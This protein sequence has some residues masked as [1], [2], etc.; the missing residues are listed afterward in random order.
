MVAC[1]GQVRAGFVRGGKGRGRH[2]PPRRAAA[3]AAGAHDASQDQPRIDR[4]QPWRILDRLIG[5]CQHR[6][7]NAPGCAKTPH[8]PKGRGASWLLLLVHGASVARSG[9]VPD[10]SKRDRCRRPLLGGHPCQWRAWMASIKPPKGSAHPN[11]TRAAVPAPSSPPF[12][13]PPPGA[14]RGCLLLRCCG[15]TAWTWTLSFHGRVSPFRWRRGWLRKP[16]TNRHIGI[17]PS[18]R[19]KK[20]GRMMGLCKD[21]WQAP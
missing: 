15:A 8:T 3:A 19:R 21:M 13:P 11:W 14:T 6:L 2:H 16:A 9:S 10:P 1:I 4:V 12:A 18:I 7:P 17:D 5:P 20:E